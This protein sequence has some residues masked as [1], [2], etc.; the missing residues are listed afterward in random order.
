MKRFEC[1]STMCN[2]M[3]DYCPDCSHSI[4]HG[5]GKDKYGKVWRWE[6][7]KWFGPTF[8]KKNGEPLKNQPIAENHPAWKPFYKWLKNRP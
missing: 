8:L 2:T 7:N 3:S 5:S 1:T 6:F 4:Y